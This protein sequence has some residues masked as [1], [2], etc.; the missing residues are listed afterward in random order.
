MRKKL[1]PWLAAC[2]LLSGCSG[3][4]TAREMGNM[5]L[6]RTL[7][8]DPSPAGVAVTGST[9]PRAKGLQAEG[10]PAL[11]LSA[12]RESLSGAC[13]A[14]QG[15][16]DSYV[17]FGYVDQLLIG[18]ELAEEGIQPVLDYFSKDAEL[19]LGAQL[20][21]VRG[22]TAR[23]ALSAGGD[24]G[25]DS[26]LETLQTDSKMGIASISRTAGETYTGLMELGSAFV[27]ALS[28]AGDDT[29]I[30][31][32]NGYGVFRDGRLTGFLDGEAARGLELLAG[33]ASSE[34]LEVELSGGRVAVKTI[35]ART[36]SE[37]KFQEDALSALKVDCKVEARLAEYRERLSAED[38][39]YLQKKL[40]ARERDRLERALEQ[41][42]S[43]GADC[44]GLGAQ[45]AMGHPARWQELSPHWSQ[46]FGQVPLEVTVELKI[47]S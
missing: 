30:L 2:L 20:W 41:L 40:E 7:G 11:T 43:W 32:E 45:A 35:S 14:M 47:N 39:K 22:S 36:K 33:G 28:P 3:L 26:R 37:L 1:F 12:E 46:Q 13:L 15:Q 16:S 19:G 5:A 17:F 42:R 9:G 4:P 34:I 18:E 38:I 29:A 25:V 23:E 44:T 6:L 10:E 8:V 27:P 21:L 31:L 24:K